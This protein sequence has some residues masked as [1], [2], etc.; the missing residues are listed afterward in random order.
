M[1][2][3][4]SICNQITL[5][6]SA[7]INTSN[8]IEYL[9]RNGEGKTADLL[10]EMRIDKVSNLQKLVVAL[11]KCFFEQEEAKKTEV[12]SGKAEEV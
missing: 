6:A 10:D 8:E 11:S 5:E 7:V 3:I 12:A 9:L 1:S 2:K 4:E